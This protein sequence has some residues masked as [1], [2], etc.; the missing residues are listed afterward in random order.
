MGAFNSY[1]NFWSNVD[2]MGG[3]APDRVCP[4]PAAPSSAKSEQSEQVE[5]VLDSGSLKSKRAQFKSQGQDHSNSNMKV[6]QKSKGP[7]L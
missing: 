6:N 3:C 2:S 1:N 4:Q 7:G 5:N